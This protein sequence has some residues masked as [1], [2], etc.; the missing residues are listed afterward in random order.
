MIVIRI[1]TLV[2]VILCTV[3]L[4]ALAMLSRVESTDTST[5]DVEPARQTESVLVEAGRRPAMRTSRSPR[6]GGKYGANIAAR[7]PHRRVATDS[8][9]A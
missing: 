4:T 2:R 9:S 3:V 6:E 1:G 7:A 5:G 8:A